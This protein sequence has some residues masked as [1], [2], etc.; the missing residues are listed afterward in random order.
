MTD[1]ERQKYKKAK[2][3]CDR[4]RYNK[5]TNEEKQK[6]LKKIKRPIRRTKTKKRRLSKTIYGKYNR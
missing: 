5:M 4:D 1:E 6:H 2:N 3:N